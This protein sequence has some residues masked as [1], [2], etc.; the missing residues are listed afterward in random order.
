LV[1]VGALNGVIDKQ[2]A[3]VIVAAL[4]GIYNV[5]RALVKQP[6]ITTLSK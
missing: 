4:T 6:E 3:T 2:T 1:V 5:L